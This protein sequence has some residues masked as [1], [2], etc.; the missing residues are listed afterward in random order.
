VNPS[1]CKILKW[2]VFA[3]FLES[4]NLHH[5]INLSISSYIPERRKSGLM[6]S[7]IVGQQISKLYDVFVIYMGGAH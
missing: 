1:I 7:Y 3:N 2:D 4:Q 5:D 6:E